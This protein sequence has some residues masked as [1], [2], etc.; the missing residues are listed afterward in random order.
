MTAAD[1]VIG[2]MRYQVLL[3]YAERRNYEKNNL[4]CI[5]N[6]VAFL[7]WN[8][9]GKCISKNGKKCLSTISYILTLNSNDSYCVGIS[10]L[11]YYIYNVNTSSEET[12]PIVG[13]IIATS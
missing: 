4:T 11:F 1:P 3:D 5:L 12:S 2:L 7:N 9:K 10:S 13:Y 6:Q 8:E